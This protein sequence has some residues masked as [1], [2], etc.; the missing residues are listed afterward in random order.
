MFAF[1]KG[2]LI[3]DYLLAS[4]FMTYFVPLGIKLFKNH[5]G[6]V[7]TKNCAMKQST[8]L[9]LIATVVCVVFF[10]I[11]YVMFAGIEVSEIAAN[12]LYKWWLF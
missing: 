8:L 10:A 11:G 1:V 6:P 7:C 9:Y 3:Y 2:A 5:D 12:I 4:V